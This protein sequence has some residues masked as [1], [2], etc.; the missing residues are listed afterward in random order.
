MGNTEILEKAKEL[1][2][3]YNLLE[4]QI[5][6]WQ[7]GFNDKLKLFVKT[8]HPVISH[9]P[10]IGNKY[11]LGRVMQYDK[12]VDKAW[13]SFSAPP[14]RCVPKFKEKVLSNEIEIIDK[15]F[16]NF[17]FPSKN[18]LEDNLDEL[19]KELEKIGYTPLKVQSA[20]K[21]FDERG[22]GTNK[23]TANGD[24]FNGDKLDW[25]GYNT[26]GLDKDGYNRDGYN[27]YGFTKDGISELNTRYNHFYQTAEGKPLDYYSF[28]NEGRY[29]KHYIKIRFD[30]KV[31]SIGQY[32]PATEND[33][34]KQRF[35][36]LDIAYSS[37]IYRAK[38]FK[39]KLDEAY[40]LFNQEMTKG[41][42]KLIWQENLKGNIH[43]L[44][45]PSSTALS[46]R[47]FD[48]LERNF[49]IKQTSKLKA[50]GCAFI[51]DKDLLMRIKTVKPSHITNN[52]NTADHLKYIKCTNQL[53][54]NDIYIII[55]DISTTGHTFE[56]CKILLTE[57]G[58][59][60]PNIYPISLFMTR[61][62]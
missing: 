26:S 47:T 31:Y 23:R 17:L 52:R 10:K 38:R 16:Y 2:T 43:L 57:N 1:E 41:I 18:P 61:E 42:E 14:Q 45:V 13:V 12:A 32:I 55:D 59:T 34:S 5:D 24:I 62:K 35:S 21:F 22:F 33:Q 15:D 40:T 28:G 49:I 48:S 19:H 36:A 37:L 20:T 25:D 39:L 7:N 6:N 50:P 58:A 4:Q 54:T 27:V 30:F 56:A 8:Q 29:I 53:D 9:H 60:P 44:C 3:K 51:D 46:E 11:G